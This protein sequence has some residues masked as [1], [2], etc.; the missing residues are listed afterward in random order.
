MGLG[1]FTGQDL[2]KQLLR[3]AGY[4]PAGAAIA[5]H[6]PLFPG[7]LIQILII[8]Y[9]NNQMR[10]DPPAPIFLDGDRFR[11]IVHLQRAIVRR[12][13]LPDLNQ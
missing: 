12:P 1:G 5:F 7:H 6:H 9:A 2:V 8:K 4:Y 11:H 13:A 3:R 10:I